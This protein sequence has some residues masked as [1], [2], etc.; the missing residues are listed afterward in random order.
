MRKKRERDCNERSHCSRK[1][2]RER[3]RGEKNSSIR[4][5]RSCFE[6]L[7]GSSSSDRKSEKCVCVSLCV[8]DKVKSQAKY[9]GTHR[10]SIDRSIDYELGDTAL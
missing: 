10:R 3:K 8:I 9:S 1:V 7:E 2:E 6:W 5:V 4:S